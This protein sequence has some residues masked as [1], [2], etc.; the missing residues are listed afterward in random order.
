MGICISIS[1]DCAPIVDHCLICVTAQVICFCAL[2]D[3]ALQDLCIKRYELMD[4]KADVSKRVMA[5]EKSHV[6]ERLTVVNH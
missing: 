2:E 3:D 5:K 6:I 4:L 1:L